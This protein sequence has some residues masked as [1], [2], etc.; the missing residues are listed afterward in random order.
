MIIVVSFRKVS[1]SFTNVINK[2]FKTAH[3][4]RII[5]SELQKHSLSHIGFG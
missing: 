2:K 5:N 4:K 1:P 3:A